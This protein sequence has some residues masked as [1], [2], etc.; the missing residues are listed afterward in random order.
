MK[1]FL[2][3]LV[4]VTVLSMGSVFTSSAM[5]AGGGHGHNSG[6]GGHGHNGGHGG[7]HGGHGSH[8][9]GYNHG[10]QHHNHGGYNHGSQQHNHG[11][12]NRPYNGGYGYGGYPNQYQQN[13]V[14]LRGNNFGVRIG[15]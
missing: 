1:S 14:Y 15:F 2:F 7:H 9:G 5:A 8:N 11:G 6:H 13:G 3:T 4:A 12:Y 10:G